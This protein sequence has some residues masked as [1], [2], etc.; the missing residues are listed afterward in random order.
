MLIQKVTLPNGKE[1]LF[2][3]LNVYQRWP[4]DEEW[5]RID[6]RLLI[7]TSIP[8]ESLVKEVLA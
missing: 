8:R 7:R 2:L 3:G 4:E 5:Q 6:E 1:L